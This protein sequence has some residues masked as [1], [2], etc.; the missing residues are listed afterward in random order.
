VQKAIEKA[1]ST[2]PQSIEQNRAEGAAADIRD[3][4]TFAEQI[5]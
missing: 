2:G 4:K 3:S 1:G 5:T